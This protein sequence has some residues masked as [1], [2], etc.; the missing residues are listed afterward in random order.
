MEFRRYEPAIPDHFEHNQEHYH[1][2]R[3]RTLKTLRERQADM[4]RHLNHFIDTAN[5]F[6]NNGA[7]PP[8]VTLEVI[9]DL[10][11]QLHIVEGLIAKRVHEAHKGTAA[12]REIAQRRHLPPDIE[13]HINSFLPSATIPQFGPQPKPKPPAGSGGKPRPKRKR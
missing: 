13:T 3:P 1:L 12:V 2:Y 10:R 5:N 4:K 7:H 9:R 6:H 11:R 8:A